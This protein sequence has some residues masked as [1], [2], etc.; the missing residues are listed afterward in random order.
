MV[1]YFKDEKNKSKKNFKKYDTLTTILKL[2]DTF[3]II[4]TTSSSITLS[5]TVIGLKAIP[6]STATA[7]GSSIC[8]KITYEIIINKYKK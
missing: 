3:V 5:H 7:F 4:A 1:R 2:F 8:D 6:K